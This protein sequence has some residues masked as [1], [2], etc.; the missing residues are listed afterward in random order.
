MSVTEK[1][2]YEQGVK[3]ERERIIELLT[4]NFDRFDLSNNG[5]DDPM[6]LETFIELI[7]G[8]TE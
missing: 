4:E 6:G 1:Q 3:A 8:K 7:K 2:F 5:V